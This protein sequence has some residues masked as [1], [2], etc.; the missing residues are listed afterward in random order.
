[1]CRCQAE[2]SRDGKHRETR[3]TGIETDGDSWDRHRRWR[4]LGRVHAPLRGGK[5][6][7]AGNDKT[8]EPTGNDRA[9]VPWPV[10]R[11]RR[12]QRVSARAALTPLRVSSKI[13]SLALR[14]GIGK[15][16][17]SLALR[18]DIC[19]SS[20]PGS[21]RSFSRATFS[22]ATPLLR[23]QSPH[24]GYR[25][26]QPQNPW[27]HIDARIIGHVLVNFPDLQDKS[28]ASPRYYQ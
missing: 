19:R 8:A 23:H 2:C 24:P 10:C 3:G 6:R 1:M 4:D 17:H 25:R 28:R 22:P 21:R 27:Q 14:A 9:S 5:R 13:H 26:R 12:S 16:M 18:A 11:F 7:R 15:K 20:R